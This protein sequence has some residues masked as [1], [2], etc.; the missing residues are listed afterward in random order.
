[1]K[2]RKI[3]LIDDDKD[4]LTITGKILGYA[5]YSVNTSSDP[6]KAIVSADLESYDLIIT[7]LVMPQIDGIEVIKNIHA[8]YPYKKIL[9]LTG[10]ATIETAVEAMRQGAYTYIEKPVESDK[11]LKKIEEVFYFE[12]NTEEEPLFINDEEIYVGESPEIAKILKMVEKVSRVESGTLI[13]G[14]SGTG[15]EVIASLIHR[16]SNRKNGPFIKINCAAIPES[17]FE[18]ELFGF[19]KGAFTGAIK[20]TKGKMELARGGT[21]FLDEIG[22]LS[23]LAQTKI[24]RAIQEKEI[25]RIGGESSVDIDF[26]LICAT[27]KDLRKLV[28][29]E[30]FREDLYYRIN[31]VT[32]ALPPLRERRTDIDGFVRYYCAAFEKT[33]KKQIPGFSEE[34]MDFF[35]SYCWPGNIRELKNVIERIYIFAEENK[36]VTLL[37]LPAELL[38][39]DP[40]S[41]QEKENTLQYKAAKLDFEKR[42]IEKMLI[43]NNWNVSKTADDIGLS[44]RN[45]HEKINQFQLFRGGNNDHGRH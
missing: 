38:N 28:E 22:D 13:L 21:L 4:F 10:N 39:A 32:L 40:G 19:V 45:L 7:D 44:R 6:M 30:K 24:L 8:K 9:V 18:S 15:K 23:L 11:L 26:R 12:S 5:G 25:Y 41:L 2:T 14:E 43:K 36:E 35:R 29:E 1:M 31:V 3:L 33:F 27:N 17:L 42:Y 20:D 37:D 34:V 16:N